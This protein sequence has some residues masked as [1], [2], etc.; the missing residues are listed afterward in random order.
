MT[1]INVSIIDNLLPLLMR[2]I[3]F[4]GLFFVAI[5]FSS[6]SSTEILHLYSPNRNQCITIITKSD[7]R[8]IIDGKHY[9]VPDSNFVKI[10]LAEMD[11]IGDGIAGCWEDEHF[12]WIILNDKTRILEN[13]LDTKRYRF[14]T[15]FSKDETGIPTFKD[16]I[17]DSCY[18]FDF[19]TFSAIPKDGVIIEK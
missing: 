18:N 13:K 4:F 12:K 19:E 14:F 6:C 1:L 7:E 9:A 3:F 17:S 2:N 16:F 10:S 11:R 5:I 15:N 8:Y